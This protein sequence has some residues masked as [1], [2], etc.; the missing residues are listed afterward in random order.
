M[1]RD[2]HLRPTPQQSHRDLPALRFWDSIDRDQ[3]EL[4]LS[5]ND[6]NDKY[7][8]F[9][10][11]LSDPT[12]ARCSFPTLLRKFNISLHEAQTIYTDH[13]RHM[14]LLQM[15]S[16]LPQVVA[17]V[18]EDAKSHMGACPRCDGEKVV[19]STRGDK[20]ARKKCP[21]CKGTGEVRMIG[22]KHAR[23]L[24]FESMKLTGQKSPLVAMQQNFV[25][26]GR[27]MMLDNNME[28]LL[29]LSAALTM[30]RRSME[31][32]SLLEPNSSSEPVSEAT[33]V[34][35]DAGTTQD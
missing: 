13:M 5:D 14:A 9:L 19:V 21:E 26:G 22:D 6:R 11:A 23:D 16:Q 34:S 24:V 31:T 32:D 20:R 35:T 28:K 33:P 7:A 1:K 17:D 10:H 8:A 29:S 12:Y 30:G 3:F 2:K 4:A 25:S 15:C 27:D 18:A